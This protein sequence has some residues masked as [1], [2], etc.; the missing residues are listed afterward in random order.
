[1]PA[2]GIVGTQAIVGDVLSGETMSYRA[3]QFG[4]DAVPP[5]YGFDP[6]RALEYFN[7]AFSNNNYELISVIFDY[8]E[9]QDNMRRNAEILQETWTTLFGADRFELVLRSGP[10]SAIYDSM[11]DQTIQMGVGSQGQSNT[12]IWTHFQVHTPYG[13]TTQLTTINNEE[14]NEWF[15]RTTQGDLV[16]APWEEK[17]YALMRMEQIMLYYM[18]M[19]PL[20]QNSNA[21]VFS[22]RV[23]LLSPEFQ[24][25]GI[26][27]VF[28]TVQPMPWD[29]VELLEP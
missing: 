6:A 9:G 15:R 1:M 23:M 5:N 12:N 24:P 20:F 2:A 22:D 19:I 8:F 16:H 11:R 21:Q 27:F 3:T 14:L 13:G 25:A 29:G 28:Y 18:P 7:I 26:G 4:L 10:P 17:A